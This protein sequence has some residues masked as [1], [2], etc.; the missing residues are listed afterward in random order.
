MQDQI[1]SALLYT[2]NNSKSSGQ[3]PYVTYA[4]MYDFFGDSAASIAE[5]TRANL[6]SWAAIV[7]EANNN[8]VPAKALEYLFGIQHDLLFKQNISSLEILTAVSGPSFSNP[9]WGLIPFSRGSVHI[10]S[11][12]P[13]AYPAIDP[14]FFLIDFDGQVMVAAAKLIRKFWATRPVSGIVV[15]ET[16]PGF[17]AVPVNAT[18]A[19]WLASIK[20]SCMYF[21]KLMSLNKTDKLDRYYQFSSTRDD[22]HDA[23][24]IGR[25][26]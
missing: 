9:Y 4:T 13:L 18:D 23:E 24:G 5:E 25:S 11:S 1:N 21:K 6:S 17:E 3:T 20:S 2:G 15:E 26:G 14:K 16:F 22:G 7:A 19:E 8:S 12:D 10:K